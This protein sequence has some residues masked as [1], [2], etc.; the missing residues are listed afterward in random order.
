ML[1]R[2]E[3]APDPLSVGSIMLFTS[4]DLVRYEEIGFLKVAQEAI[5]HPRCT[6]R[7]ETGDYE[8][9]WETEQGQAFCGYSK[10]LSEIFNVQPCKMRQ[11]STETYG[12][13]KC[14][15]AIPSA[16]ALRKPASF[17]CTWTKSAIPVWTQ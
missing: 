13:D 10:D 6:Y 15:P 2:N 1:R 12:I 14:V 17:A 7:A 8:V 11:S 16:L 3:N 5:R 4:K 9:Y